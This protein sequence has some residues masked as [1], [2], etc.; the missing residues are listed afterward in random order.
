MGFGAH[1][2]K[3]DH[4][5]QV[6]AVFGLPLTVSSLIIVGITVEKIPN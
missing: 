1:D 2:A 3:I 4:H 5:E 6:A